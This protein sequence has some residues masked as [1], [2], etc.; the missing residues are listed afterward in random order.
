MLR[1]QLDFLVLPLTDHRSLWL[2]VG[3]GGKSEH[4]RTENLC[5]H[6]STGAKRGSCFVRERRMGIWLYFGIISLTQPD[7][8]VNKNPTRCNSM[9]MFIHCKVTLHILGAVTPKICR[10]TLQ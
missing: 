2:P 6:A 4:R 3:G 8:N 7:I 1:K 10:V 5:S 9:Q